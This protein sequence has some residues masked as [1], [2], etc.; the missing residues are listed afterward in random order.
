M[1]SIKI[2]NI[3]KAI[4]QLEDYQKSLEDRSRRLLERLAEIGIEVAAARFSSAQYDGVNDVVVND[5][6]EWVDKTKLIIS[7]TGSAVTFI[8]FGTGVHY[9]EQHPKAEE[10]GAMRGEYGQGKGS[11]DSWT[12]YGDP[13]T[14]GKV[15]RESDKGTVVRTHGNPPARA[16]YDAGKEMRER[17]L[18]VSR[19]VFGNS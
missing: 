12:Y 2:E 13:G 9:A 17:I 4:K 6:P 5:S 11:R 15:V 18:E 3:D 16:M 19:E 14:N 7:A 8:E 10:L 1:I